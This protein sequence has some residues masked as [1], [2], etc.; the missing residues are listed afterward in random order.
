VKALEEPRLILRGDAD[1]P[2]LDFDQCL[3]VA[4]S[5]RKDH[6]ASRRGVLHRVR[7]QIVE[8]MAQQL[9]V[10][11]HVGPVEAV[12][13]IDDVLPALGDAKLRHDLAAELAQV[14]PGKVE[15]E[16]AGLRAP[17]RK[18]AVDHFTHSLGTALDRLQQVALFRG[19]EVVRVVLEQFG[20]RQ[21]GRE[22]GAELMRGGRDEF[23]L[24]LGEF[25]RALHR[26][27]QLG[28]GACDRR[29]RR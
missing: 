23:R 7:K 20:G 17:E 21:H 22:R 11:V 16:H 25:L 1:P 10:H 27:Q 24:H 4:P 6:F 26:R 14:H 18:N 8:D 2:I 19:V 12:D 9:L 15:L 28:F 13:K 29:C 3:L 5:E